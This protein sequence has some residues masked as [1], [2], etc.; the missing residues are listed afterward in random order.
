ME[1]LIQPGQD[2]QTTLWV[3]TRAARLDD[4]RRKTDGGAHMSDEE[5]LI[6]A[7]KRR[8]YMLRLEG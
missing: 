7:A 1:N 3:L 2:A 8:G 6:G 4:L 5:L